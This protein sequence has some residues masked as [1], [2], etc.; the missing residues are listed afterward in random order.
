MFF[1]VLFVQNF[2]CYFSEISQGTEKRQNKFITP[3]HLEPEKVFWYQSQLN[4][5][6]FLL[7]QIQINSHEFYI[8]TL[9]LPFTKIQLTNDQMNIEKVIFDAIF[10][11]FFSYDMKQVYHSIWLLKISINE[12]EYL[13]FRVFEYL[14][15]ILKFFDNNLY[16]YSKFDFLEFTANKFIY[17]RF[18]YG[19]KYFNTKLVFDETFLLIGI[20]IIYVVYKDYGSDSNEIKKDWIIRNFIDESSVVW[21]ETISEQNDVFLKGSPASKIGN[22]ILNKTEKTAS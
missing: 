12:N 22:L 7:K 3:K 16:S 6:F 21:V 5:Y 1:T 4:Q 9:D 20:K 15:I 11:D 13:K 2:F 14:E 8:L 10:K 19:V 18:D 17:N